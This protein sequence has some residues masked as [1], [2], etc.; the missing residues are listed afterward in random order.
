MLPDG[1]RWKAEPS[2][3]SEW[4]RVKTVTTASIWRQPRSGIDQAEQEQQV[5]VAGEDVLDAELDEARWRRAATS[6]SAPPG[7]RGS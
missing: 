3:V 4:A 5:V 7:P 2:S 1:A 6:G